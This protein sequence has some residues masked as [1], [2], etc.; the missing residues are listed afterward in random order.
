MTIKN[1]KSFNKTGVLEDNHI[2]KLKNVKASEFMESNPNVTEKTVERVHSCSSFMRFLK[3]FKVD[4]RL[5]ADMKKEKKVIVDGH[6]C[7][8]RFCPICSKNKAKKDAIRLSCIVQ[9][10]ADQQAQQEF[11]RNEFS[12]LFLT[13]TAPNCKGSELSDLLTTMNDAYNRL[14]KLKFFQKISHGYAKKIEVTYNHD[15]DSKSFDTYH[16]HF[17]ILIAVD[18]SYFTNPKL[19]IKHEEWLKAWQQVMKDPTITQ[20]NIKKAGKNQSMIKAIKEMTKYMAKDSDYLYNEEVFNNF[21][22]SLKGRRLMTYSG[23]FKEGT[24]LYENGALDDYKESSTIRVDDYFRSAWLNDSNKYDNIS[25][26][27]SDLNKHDLDYIQEKLLRRGR[28]L[29]T[30]LD[31]E[32]NLQLYV[33]Y[34]GKTTYGKELKDD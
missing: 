33:D 17:H 9:W 4:E 28:S 7:G 27:T 6:F 22:N 13:L 2:G 32:N 25:T 5:K 14:T 29:S 3:G 8:N 34:I 12:F 24:T 26:S 21:Y 18:K 1:K 19:Y 31:D 16:P 11:Q 23:L 20:V 15:K 30:G 10:L